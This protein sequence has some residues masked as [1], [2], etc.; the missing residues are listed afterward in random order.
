MVTRGRGVLVVAAYACWM[1]AWGAGN[2][3]FAAPDEWAHY[4]RA[5]GLVQGEWVGEPTREYADPHLSG[6]QLKWVVQATRSVPVPPGLVPV[7]FGCN[8][9]H[10]EQSARCLSEAGADPQATHATTPTG[11]Y[12][13]ALYVLPGLA[14]LRGTSPASALGAGRAASAWLCLVLL[15]GAFA[16][17]WRE[18]GVVSW[19]GLVLALTPMA[20]ALSATLNTSGPEI[21]SGIAFFAALLRLVREEPAPRWV[22]GLAASA[23]AVLALSR[24][25]GAVWVVAQGVLVL[26]WRGPGALVRQARARPVAAGV[27]AGVLG[28][29]MV[30]NRLWE[31]VYGPRVHVG[32][33]GLRPAWRQARGF[34]PG[35]LREQVG[36]FQYLDTPM[37]G[38]TYGA[39]AVLGAG[40][41]AAAL[42]LGQRRDRVWLV[43]T[44]VG[45]L[46]APA[47][48]YVAVIRHNGWTVQGRHVLPIT[49][50]LPLLAGEV[51][52][53]R[54]G[55]STRARWLGAGVLG[56]VAVLQAV[57][58]WANARR[59]AVGTLGPVWFWS[60]PEWSPP[61]GWWPWTGLVLAGS[62]MMLLAG[63]QERWRSAAR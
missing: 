21:L 42:W 54:V 57:A 38:W 59:S 11:T 19:V 36:V 34:W 47:V 12:P 8:T 9:F 43:L 18:E 52:A 26:V 41:L 7:G 2:P 13:P 37:P 15:A 39:W 50:T 48:L 4:L 51:L 61:L 56:A 35:W 27:T 24:S 28:V 53:R 63:V 33:E 14:A 17:S 30:L 25:M 62:G 5:L 46:V 32:L 20:V 60:A 58:W 44:A 55:D 49:V 22:W 3:P 1:M 29:A 23:G 16:A 10:S 31:A 45:A 6:E 40:V